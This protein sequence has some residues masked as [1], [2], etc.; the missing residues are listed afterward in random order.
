VD[1]AK[2]QFSTMDRNMKTSAAILMLGLT[3][4]AGPALADPGISSADNPQPAIAS[5]GVYAQHAGGKIVYHYRVTNKSQQN[6]TAVSIGRDNQN[7]TNPGNDINEL[8]DLP[9]GWNPKLG[10]PTTSANSPT[11]W[12]VSVIAPEEDTPHA[13][14]W[15]IMNV[16]SPKIL[17]GQTVSKMSIALDHPDNN[18]LSGHALITYDDGNPLDITVPLERLDITPPSLTVILSPDTL[19][20]QNDKLVAIKASFI[21]RDDY[22]RLPEVKLES[23]TANEPL[24]ASD[25]SDASIGLDDRYFKF[26]AESKSPA[27]RIYTVSYSATDASGNQSIASATVAVTKPVAAPTPAF[28]PHD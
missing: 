17:T 16:H 18:Y 28:G 24:G 7:D 4:L 2:E 14:A 11:G 12:R 15:E 25:I 19:A 21:V 27:G 5:V 9:L 23:I 26:L 8:H 1:K 3:G 10:I 6:I 20:A 13:I 22:D